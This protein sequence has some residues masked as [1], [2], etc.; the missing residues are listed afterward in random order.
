MESFL[1]KKQKYFSRGVLGKD[2]QQSFLLI[3]NLNFLY[4]ELSKKNSLN[5]FIARGN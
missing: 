4:E 1:I 2:V 5:R 3:L